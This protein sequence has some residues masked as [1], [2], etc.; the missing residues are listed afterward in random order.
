MYMFPRDLAPPLK[1]FLT[2]GDSVLL[3]GPRQTGKTTLLHLLCPQG[4]HYDFADPGERLRIAANPGLLVQEIRG[5]LPKGGLFTIDEIQKIPTAFD[6]VQVLLDD[7]DRIYTTL[8]TGSSARK[9]KRGAVNTL[10]G[11]ILQWRLGPLTAKELGF[12]KLKNETERSQLLL[13][14]MTRGQLPKVQEMSGTRL[15]RHLRSYVQTYLEQEILG[16]ALTKDVGQFARFLAVIASRSGQILNYS[17]LSQESGASV[18]TIKHHVGVLEDTLTAHLIPGFSLNDTKTWLS[19]PRLLLFDL[20][21][22]NAASERVIDEKALLPEYGT[23]FEQWVGLEILGWMRN[24]EPPFHL[25]YW[26]TT[27]KREIDWVLR[28]GDRI[29]AVEAKWG[30]WHRGDLTH[31]SVFRRLMQER[32]MDVTTCLVCS[33]PHPAREAAHHIIP[34]HLLNETLEEWAV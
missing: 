22:R 21:V 19:T 9:I 11:R 15:A 14:M 26:R 10:P 17:S 31:L 7:R 6:A 24:Q 30:K 32:K 34:P 4:V 8:L 29:L 16:D 1:K 25:F 13:S 18:N 12:Y 5:R 33:T 2:E 27:Q 3:L 28:Q 20:G 23:L